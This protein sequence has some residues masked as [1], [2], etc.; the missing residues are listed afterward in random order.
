MSK[1]FYYLIDEQVNKRMIPDA[2]EC[3]MSDIEWGEAHEFFTP[4]YWLTQYWMNEL[5]RMSESKYKTNATLPEELTFCLLG[6]F[7]VTAELAATAFERC[8]ESGLID[9]YETDHTRWEEDL[10]RPLE[11]E[12][13]S[14]RYRYPRQ[15]AKY[16]AS[17][18]RVLKDDPWSQLKGKQMRDY[19]L[20]LKGVGPKTASWIVRNLEDSD[21][22]AI[23]D[24]HLIRAGIITG[25]FKPTHSVDKHYSDMESIFI[26]F[27]HRLGALPSRLDCLIWDQMRDMG[28]LGL[29]LFERALHGPD[30]D[31][32]SFTTLGPTRHK[33]MQL[34]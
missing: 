30:K 5:D 6:G 7:G 33:Q 20:T 14:R 1:P 27:C 28:P 15:K 4:C 26:E 24:I 23:L 11:V 9:S 29:R 12:G 2:K 25:I 32:E 16:L 22:V 8:K 3:F 13:K 10:S 19:L 18:M 34:V 31:N 21:E 17:A